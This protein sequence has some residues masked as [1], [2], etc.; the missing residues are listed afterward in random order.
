MVRSV[1]HPDVNLIWGSAI[2]D[3]LGDKVRVTI[4]AAGFDADARHTGSYTTSSPFL[5]EAPTTVAKSP[6]ADI[7]GDVDDGGFDFGGDDDIPSFLR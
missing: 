3:A 1:A 6:V 7:F 5:T 2:D 4:I